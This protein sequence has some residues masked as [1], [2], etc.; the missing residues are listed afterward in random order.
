MVIKNTINIL[1][2]LFLIIVFS[3][4]NLK[5]GVTISDFRAESEVNQVILN[6]TA[7]AES[8]VKTYEI[9]RSTDGNNFEKV[10]IVTPFNNGQEENKY[11]YFDRSVFKT[12]G[13]TY[14]YRLKIVDSN[15]QATIYGETV[16]ISPQISS[17]R[18]TWGSLKAMFR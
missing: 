8:D 15:G 7:R 13:R 9:L 18:H 5:A 3:Q 11:K 4:S 10:G 16:S 17:V 14:Y 1:K 2:L 6:W 12:T